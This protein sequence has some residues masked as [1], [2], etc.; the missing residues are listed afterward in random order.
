M[1]NASFNPQQ[2]PPNGQPPA[3]VGY[4]P[5]LSAGQTLLQNV[6]A[7][8]GV[9]MQQPM[10]APQQ[11]G[12]FLPPQ[13]PMPMSQPQY[14]QPQMQA[15]QQPAPYPGIMNP[16]PQANAA[17]PTMI[18]G[19]PPYIHPSMVPAGQSPVPQPQPTAPVQPQ[20]FVPQQFVPQFSQPNWL[21][22]GQQRA[23][24]QPP[25][26]LPTAP[27][28]GLPAPG[29][30]PGLPGNVFPGG[31][32]PQFAQQPASQGSPAS[33]PE[34]IRLQNDL[35]ALR[36]QLGQTQVV[37]Q[38]SQQPQQPAATQQQQAKSSPFDLD[39]WP[40][41]DGLMIQEWR[42]TRQLPNGQTVTDWKPNTPINVRMAGDSY[43]QHVASWEHALLYAP[44]RVLPDLIRK[45]V[46]DEAEKIVGDRLATSENSTRVDMLLSAND[47]LFHTDP[48]T[49]QMALNDYGRKMVAV[50]QYQPGKAPTADDVR[51]LE[52]A[53]HTVKA[54]RER[55]EARAMLM[56]MQSGMVPMQPGMQPGMVAGMPQ[57]PANPIAFAQPLYPTQ[58]QFTQ[59]QQLA[60]Q[61]AQPPAGLP[62]LPAYVH[63]M[64][65]PYPQQAP[66]SPGADSAINHR[67]NQLDRMAQN[68]VSRN[69]SLPQNGQ[70]PTQQL[71]QNQHLTPGQR[72]LQTLRY[73]AQPA[74]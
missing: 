62:G 48:A 59:P 47:W 19:L 8:A 49:G 39:Q 20:Q 15:P 52:S 32:A 40:E 56:A 13:L 5:Q 68:T 46:R 24:S 55:D 34:M 11:S 22:Q 2:P 14:T 29:Y 45:Y 4:A 54:E 64:N 23:G 42:E 74:F 58:P 38:Q 30:Q 28:G 51:N 36:Q 61:Y 31:I 57:R 9:P 27:A 17:P 65:A 44:Q 21:P 53:L 71:P 33:N 67:L 35:A 41:L 16:A 6:A 60:P 1:L 10:Q 70:L 7:Q 25:V 72:M 26:G 43:L 37:Q 66:M 69:G 73:G 50:A 12:G 3:P 18:A 63:P